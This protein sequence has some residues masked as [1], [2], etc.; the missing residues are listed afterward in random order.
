MRNELKNA[1][2]PTV[3]PDRMIRFW[4]HRCDKMTQVKAPLRRFSINILSLTDLLT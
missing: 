4:N 3:S 1:L 2:K